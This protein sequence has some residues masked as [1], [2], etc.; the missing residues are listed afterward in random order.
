[1]Y[2]KRL[3][4]CEAGDVWTIVG[5]CT[6]RGECPA[7]DFLCGLDANYNKDINRVRALFTHVAQ[8]GPTLLPVE[9]SHNIAPEIFEFIRGKL[10][11]AWFY[12]EGGK[13]VICSHGFVKKGQKTPRAEID[14]AK[15]AKERYLAAFR[16]GE[17]T[18]LEEE[19]LGHG[20]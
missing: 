14:A 3:K 1:M 11:I 16:R 5:V 7:D 6:D 4:N 18:I 19:S 8:Q 13:M 20:V 12:G 10:R 2:L 15:R 17:V 9:V